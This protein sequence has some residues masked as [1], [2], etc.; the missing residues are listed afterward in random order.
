[1]SPFAQLVVG[2]QRD[3]FDAGSGPAFGLLVGEAFTTNSIQVQPGAGV[4]I[5][6]NETIGFVGQVDYRVVFRDDDSLPPAFT[7]A[8]SIGKNYIR[9][10]FGIRVNQR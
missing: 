9:Y 5:P 2:V 6:L 8:R 10:V 4:V 7:A 1:M 3:V